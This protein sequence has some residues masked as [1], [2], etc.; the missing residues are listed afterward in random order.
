MRDE[1]ERLALSVQC[2]RCRSNGPC[3]TRDGG[4]ATNMH[5]RRLDGFREAFGLG[6]LQALEDDRRIAAR[7]AAAQ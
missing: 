6:Y 2:P 4:R 3:K 5:A 7:R 1:L